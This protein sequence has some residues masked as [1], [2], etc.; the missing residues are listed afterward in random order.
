MVEFD[1]A[2][3]DD[4]ISGAKRT[5]QNITATPCKIEQTNYTNWVFR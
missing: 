3:A 5:Q 1:E 2:H 4:K